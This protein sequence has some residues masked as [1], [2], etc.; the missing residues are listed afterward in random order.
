MTVLKIL[1]GAAEVV[2]KDQESRL[3]GRT[4]WVMQLRT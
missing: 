1:T 2:I 3:A 4:E